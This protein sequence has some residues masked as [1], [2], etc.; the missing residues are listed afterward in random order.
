MEDS[1]YNWV[2]FYMEL[3]TRLL[4]YKEK[5]S[6]LIEKVKKLV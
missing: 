1:R 3:A 6:E 2:K 5:R 4:A